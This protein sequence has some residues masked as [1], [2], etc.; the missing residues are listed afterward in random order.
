MN[1]FAFYSRSSIESFSLKPSRGLVLRWEGDE[2]SDKEKEYYRSSPLVPLVK[3]ISEDLKALEIEYDYLSNQIKPE[4][5]NKTPIGELC[6]HI[7]EDLK[8]YGVVEV[9]NHIL[10]GFLSTF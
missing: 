3:K 7:Y 6:K 1:V 9:S 10:V 4:D 2:P 5:P 8:K